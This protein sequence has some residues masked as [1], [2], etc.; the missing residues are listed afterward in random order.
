MMKRTM[1]AALLFGS[2]GL[3][4]VS[5]LADSCEFTT[6]SGVAFG[7]YD[8][9]TGSH[10]DSDGSITLS[11]RKTGLGAIFGGSIDYEIRLNAGSSGSFMPRAMSSG[12]DTLEYNLY[13]EQT[14][15][16]VWGDGAGG[17]VSKMGGLS[18]GFLAGDK[19]ETFTIYGRVFGGQY[20][21]AGTYTDMITAT[22]LY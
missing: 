14:R 20:V 2:A 18:F 10:R 5:A 6:T 16:T 3:W 4:S 21:S 7:L 15:N 9:L 8:P 11:C 22:V 1:L 12:V 19:T 17:T 13:T